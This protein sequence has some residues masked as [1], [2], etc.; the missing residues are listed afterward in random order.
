MI[1]NARK[2][3]VVVT[4]TFILSLLLYLIFGFV[5]YSG[6]QYAP[7]FM[8]V[9]IFILMIDIVLS[10]VYFFWRFFRWLIACFCKR[11]A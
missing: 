5:Y 1:Y 7:L 6:F 2:V 11:S 8:K 3:E 4:T 10:L 9:I